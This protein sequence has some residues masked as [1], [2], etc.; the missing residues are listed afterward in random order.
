MHVFGLVVFLLL[1]LAS[2]AA[3]PLGVPGTLLIVGAAALYGAMTG[4]TTVP[5]SVVLVLLGV[6]MAGEALDFFLGLAGAKSKGATK[7]GMAGAFFGGLIGAFMGFPVPLLG[8]IA[9]AFIGALGGAFLV[10]LTV[11]SNLTRALQVGWGTL[12]GRIFSSIL[13]LALAL[14]MVVYVAMTGL[15]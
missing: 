10:E 3:I 5:L 6:A 15:T 1:A 13:K 12:L 2:L 4:W 8:N 9:G 14:G 11:T 7:S